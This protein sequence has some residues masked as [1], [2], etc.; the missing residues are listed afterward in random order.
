MNEHLYN[1]TLHMRL[2]DIYRFAKFS[3]IIFTVTDI[4]PIVAQE[5]NGTRPSADTMI[6]KY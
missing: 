1:R 6:V 5:A 2:S 4:V 3:Q